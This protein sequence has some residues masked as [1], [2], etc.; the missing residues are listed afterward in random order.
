MIKN[1]RGE[2]T[3]CFMHIKKSYANECNLLV[4]WYNAP[5]INNR[6]KNCPFYK[7][8]EQVIKERIKYAKMSMRRK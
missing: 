2:Y 8:R 3:D 1:Q 6:C 7:T 5:D 4:D